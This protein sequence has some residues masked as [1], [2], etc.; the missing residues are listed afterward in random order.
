MFLVFFLML[1]CKSSSS[2]GTSKKFMRY[3][4]KIT[5]SKYFQQAT[6]YKVIKRAM[7]NVSNTPLILTVTINSLVGKLALNIPPPPS[8][9]LWYCYVRCSSVFSFLC[10]SSPIMA[11]PYFQM[12]DILSF[13]GVFFKCLF[14]SVK[15]QQFPA[16]GSR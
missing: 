15:S 10:K 16:V 13:L 11:S 5:Q 6:E 14:V 8:D 12:F 4:N 7:E 9:R 2:G 1:L 3:L